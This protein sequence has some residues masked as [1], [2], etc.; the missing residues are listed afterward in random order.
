MGSFKPVPVLEG[1][2]DPVDSLTYSPGFLFVGF[3]SG[4]LSKYIHTHTLL[5][6]AL[7]MLRKHTPSMGYPFEH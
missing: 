7:I 5:R 6:R 2:N 3:R 4:K 1:V